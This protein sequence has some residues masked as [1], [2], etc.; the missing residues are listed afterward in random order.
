MREGLLEGGRAGVAQPLAHVHEHV[1]AEGREALR[2]HGRL[3]WVG[4]G[5]VGKVRVGVRARVRV[6]VR[7]RVRARVRV[8]V[9]VWGEG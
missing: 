1:A 4:W 9:R 8:S 6:R 2:S 7:V 3:R 5:W